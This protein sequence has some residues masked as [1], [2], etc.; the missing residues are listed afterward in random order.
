VLPPLPP[1]P[2]PPQAPAPQQVAQPCVAP[3]PEQPL[4]IL[5]PP[6][7]PSGPPPM[8]KALH[9]DD[10][11]DTPLG[12]WHTEAKGIVR[13]AQCGKAL[14][15]YAVHA[16][17]NDKGEAVLIN[18]KPKSDSQWT[19]SVYSKA[20]GDTYYGTIDMKGANTLHVEACAFGRFYCTGNNWTR[21]SG[22]TERMISSRQVDSRPRS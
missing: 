3:T 6:P 22:E 15:G 7:A 8:Q 1:V 20:S 5:P 10:S 12:D 14:C 19:G 18:M 2:A 16:S 9:E 11:F 4:E 13:I 17:S 21:I